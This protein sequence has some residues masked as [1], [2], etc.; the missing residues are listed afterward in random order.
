MRP[1][2]PDL[3]ISVRDHDGEVEIVHVHADSPAEQLGLERG[4]AIVS[5]HGWP[6]R[7]A[8][9]L[10]WLLPA[11]IGYARLQVRNVRTRQVVTRVLNA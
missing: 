2:T 1:S 11:G 5:I 10:A 7:H 8:T 9:D 3:G 6:L 4:D